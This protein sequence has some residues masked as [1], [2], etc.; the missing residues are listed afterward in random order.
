ME[1]PPAMRSMMRPWAMRAVGTA[2]GLTDWL[3]W[4]TS[5]VMRPRHM[6]GTI[7]WPNMTVRAMGVLSVPRQMMW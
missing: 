2:L 1:M 3:M 7:K 4:V 5:A 6:I